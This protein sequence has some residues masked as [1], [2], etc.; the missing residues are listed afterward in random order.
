[1]IGGR[2]SPTFDG[3]GAVAGVVIRPIA[4]VEQ[5]VF[6]GGFFVTEL[7]VNKREIVMSCEIL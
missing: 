2:I 1:M 7:L 3:D 5:L 6:G 4:F